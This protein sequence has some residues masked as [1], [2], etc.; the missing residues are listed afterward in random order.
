M[1]EA[2]TGT[3]V[4]ASGT[5]EARPPGHGPVFTHLSEVLDHPALSRTEKRALL[6]AWA[7]DAC[8]VEGRPAWRQLPE[9]G[10]LVPIDSILDALRALDGRVLH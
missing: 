9:S 10:A 6:A 4:L 2:V 8:A 5:L 3:D 1:N 7:S